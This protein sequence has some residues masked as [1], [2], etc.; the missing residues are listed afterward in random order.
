MAEPVLS[1]IPG[2]K[3]AIVGLSVA[4]VVIVVL[5]IW[6]ALYK[7]AQPEPGLTT[8]ESTPVA[9]ASPV[10]KATV[11]PSP[12][13]TVS[14]ATAA[15]LSITPNTK[16]YQPLINGNNDMSAGTR[17][18]TDT[19]LLRSFVA[20]AAENYPVVYYTDNFAP[21]NKIY[22]K[23]I[24]TGKVKTVVTEERGVGRVTFN[25]AKQ[26]LAYRTTASDEKSYPSSDIKILDLKTNKTVTVG[27]TKIILA[28]AWSPDGRYL[29][30]SQQ[31]SDANPTN[32]ALK[33]YDTA[34]AK[35]VDSSAIGEESKGNAWIDDSKSVTLVESTDELVVPSGLIPQTH[36]IKKF[37]VADNKIESLSVAKGEI[38]FFDRQ[39]VANQMFVSTLSQEESRDFSSVNGAEPKRRA[40]AGASPLSWL[41]VIDLSTGAVT[42]YRKET[43]DF[44]R[45]LLANSTATKAVFTTE[46]GTYG[47]GDYDLALRVLDLKTR[48]VTGLPDVSSS[49]KQSDYSIVGWN[50]D[51]NNVLLWQRSTGFYNVNIVTKELTKITQE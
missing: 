18:S 45:Q 51:E 30:F 19:S 23:N 3:W 50:G 40:P 42:D 28:L 21:R 13:P 4:G 1:K 37:V 27:Q 47:K 33:F 36:T 22:E 41:N 5:F 24:Y 7:S 39:V 20:H 9:E 32:A 14:P 25:T 49:S 2:P 12:T 8:D 46:T 15:K 31:V 29:M 10:A 11:A 48:Q 34:S 17:I 44:M 38:H 16:L 43:G 26:L 6:G 35:V